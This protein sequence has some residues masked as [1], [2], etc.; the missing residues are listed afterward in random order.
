MGVAF[1]KAF[2][3]HGVATTP[4]H[5]VDNSGDG[6]RDSHAVEISERSLREV[7]LPPFEAVIK[8]GGASTVMSSYN[9]LNGVA[10]SANHWLLT[11]I[12]RGEYGFK[13]WVAS[14]YGAVDGIFNLHHNTGSAR[15][16]AAAAINAGMD[17]EWPSVYIFGKGL[18]DAVKDGLI[19]QKTLDESVRRVLRIK[20]KVGMFEDP[21]ADEA[22][23]EQIVQSAAHRQTALDAARQAMT[24]LKND[25]HSLPLSKS[26]HTI[27][28]IGQ[29]AKGGDAQ[30][31]GYSGTNAPVISILD[32]IKAKLGSGVHVEYAKGG[33]YSGGNALPAIPASAFRNLKG[34]YFTNQTLSGTPEIVRS[35]EQIDFNWG[36]GSPNTLIPAD[37]FS[38]RWTGS[39]VAPKTGD[40]TIS[41]TSDD[42]SRLFINGKQVIDEWA[43]H[44]A[45]AE[46][47]VVHLEAGEAVSFKL[48]YF[49]ETGQASCQL[50]WGLQGVAS[51][52]IAEAVELA[53][54]SDVA[55]I[56]AGIIEGEGQDRAFLDLPGNQEEMI[57]KVAATGT[58]VVVV[59]MAGAPVTMQHWVNQVPAI[60]DAWYPGQEGGT[61]VADV[62]FGDV[63]PG[64]RLPMTFPLS[65]GQCPTYY[66]LEPTGRGY[67]YVDLS[68]KPQFPFGF[69]LS[70]TTFEYSNLKVSPT[71]IGKKQ[72]V[73]VSFDVTNTGNVA[74]DETPQLYLHQEV[75]SIVRPL[76][77]LIN[78]QRTSLA[79]GEK[80]TVT[81]TV[82]PDQLAI[83]NAKMKR[84]VEPGK[85]EFMVG[86]SAED[87]KLH[88]ETTVK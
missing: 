83:W 73:E 24:L 53:K 19:S 80:R 32:G 6:G 84:V 27:A 44:A 41:L 39:L 52:E 76:K 51:P 54:K 61:A 34:E 69:G 71:T 2:E 8:E 3:S 58:P 45:K 59:L 46:T 9:S 12:L 36:D 4:K 70:Y 68:G 77:Q 82:K 21:Y 14:D 64:G 10:C 49:E 60:V 75:S 25:G 62:L 65:V 30:L 88:G 23:V 74:G 57:Q 72:N 28:V 79:P 42:G 18:D 40:Y 13:G 47:T 56:V 35:D 38:A 67:D 33:S 48:E 20:F 43:V 55:V 66:N 26:I 86:S 1:V 29:G 11:D 63:N 5:Y 50:G 78:F 15:D 87:I 7:Y 31:G 37:H 85:F 81:F 16:T 22:H 17:S